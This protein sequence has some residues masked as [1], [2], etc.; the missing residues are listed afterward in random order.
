M[1]ISVKLDANSGGREGLAGVW[2]EGKELGESYRL[3]VPLR[4]VYRRF[5]VPDKIVLDFAVVASICYAIDKVVPRYD[6]DD[7]WTR[8]LEV[9]FAVSEP[10]AWNQVREGF[11]RA[12]SF[13]SGD[14][15]ITSFRRAKVPL[16]QVPPGRIF[17]IKPTRESFDAAC[18]FS[19]G[20]DSLAGAIELLEN[21]N[22]SVLLIGHYDSAG[23]RMQ[24]ENLTVALK[25]AY[26]DRVELRQIRASQNPRASAERTL[27]SRSIAFI[28]LGL[29]AASA[30]G[31]TV[32]LYTC[33]NGLIALNPALT[34]SRS[35][36][37]STRTM[38]PYY[39][40]E[41]A[42][43]LKGLG[44]QNRIVNP[45]G[46]KT[47]GECIRDCGNLALLGRV[48]RQSA[49][50]SHGSRR[51]MWTRR[52]QTENCGYCVPCLYRRSALHLSGLDRGSEYGIDIFNPEE[53]GFS[54]DSS[55]SKD[56]QA[57]LSFVKRTKTR[58]QIAREITRSSSLENLSDYTSMV[59]RGLG[60][61]RTWVRANAYPELL[62]MAG[63]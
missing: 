11:D 30:V 63:I 28:G 29:L 42:N 59:D 41:L 5:G 27:R 62:A 48:L 22:K 51:Q 9:E 58:N 13:L 46:F 17:A 2:I 36:S 57:L 60:E 40:G 23:P 50:C 39:L 24:Q 20:L 38:H 18:L 14:E 12:L 19:G 10:D 4:N 34:P 1:K 55:L 35:G 25:K 54:A 37:C 3:D 61:L 31:K 26:G 33:E 45:Y 15:W 43:V 49:S 6:F 7:R 56:L 53:L 8:K 52:S 21:E 44:I 32:P 47:K 16:F